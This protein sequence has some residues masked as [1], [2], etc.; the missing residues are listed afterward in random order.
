MFR[1]EPPSRIEFSNSS[2]IELRCN[3][4]GIPTPKITWQTRDG[5]LARDI[6]GLRHT[7]TDGTL[8]FPPFPKTDYR[9]DVHDTVYQC[10]ASNNVGSVLSRES[11]VRGGKKNILLFLLLNI[12]CDYGEVF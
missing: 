3:A 1:N 11:H 6:P 9:Q 5:A 8:V 10:S 12:L 2:G 7:R 4:D